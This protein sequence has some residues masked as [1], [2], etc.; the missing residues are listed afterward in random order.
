M[1]WPWVDFFNEIF[2]IQLTLVVIYV[3]IYNYS[4]VYYTLLYTFILFFLFGISLSVFQLEL[5]TAFL[6]LIECSVIFVFLLLLFYLNIKNVY[7]HTNKLFFN[8]FLLLFYF[9]YL[10]VVTPNTGLFQT[11]LT[12]YFLLD[13]SYESVFN[14]LQNDLFV[15]FIS[16]YVLNNIEFIFIGLLLLVGSIVCVNLYSVN[17]NTR[18]QNYKSFFNVFNF[19]LDMCSFSFLRK[20]NLIKQGNTKS[21]LKIFL[22]K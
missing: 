2:L 4:S 13:N 11:N 6:W 14:F 1:W 16:Y 10:I 12:L 3:Y 7:V 18:L 21:S 9:L 22:K 15:L 8:Y 19:F 5:F 17:K 20:Q